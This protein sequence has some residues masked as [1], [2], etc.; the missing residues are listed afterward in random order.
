MDSEMWDW[1]TDPEAPWWVKLRR[2]RL[3]IDEVHQRVRVLA[4][5]KPWSLERETTEDPDSWGYRFRIHR[6]IP[7]DLCAAVGDAVANMR[8]ALDYAAYELAVRHA[9]TLTPRQE[10][11]TAFPICKDGNT[12]DR[13]FTAGQSGP[14]RAEIYG[15]GERNALRCVQPF[16]LGEEARGLGIEW[17][18]SADHELLTDGAW[19]LNTVWNIDKH[20]RLTALAWGRD[21][22]FYWQGADQFSVEQWRVLVRR[23]SFLEDN[24]LILELRGAQGDG[25]PDVQLTQEINLLLADDP[26]PYKAALVKRLEQLH[27]SLSGWVLPRLF[28]TADGNPPPIMISFQ[29]PG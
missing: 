7:A 10:K 15:Q 23:D 27:Q 22:F 26:S 21:E 13:F 1:K 8:S 11:A 28:A 29:P 24:Q 12:F 4:A 20:R 18:A 6:P 9:G 5:S 3:H 19:A 16:T 2:A 25:R 17:S 14:V